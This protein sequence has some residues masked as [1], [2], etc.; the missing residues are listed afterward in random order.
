MRERTKLQVNV[1]RTE[2]LVVRIEKVAPEM[3][4]EINGKFRRLGAL[5]SNLTTGTGAQGK[6]VVFENLYARL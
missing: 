6:E 5:P 2:N 1:E 3:K 4:G